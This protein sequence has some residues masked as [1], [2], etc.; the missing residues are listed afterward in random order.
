MRSTILR[1]LAAVGLPAL[2]LLAACGSDDDG[3]DGAGPSTT[4]AGTVAP[5]EG[6]VADGRITICSDTP[7]EPFEFKDDDGNDTG[8]DIDLVGAIA[9]QAGLTTSVTDL[10][11]DGIL[12]S[13]AAGDCDVVAAAVT[14]TD[15]RKQQVDFSDPYFDADQSLLVKKDSGIASIADLEGE[16]VG[17]QTG[18]TGESYA[19]DNATG[20]TVKSFEDADGLFSALE[21]GEIVAILQD[22]P[23]NGFRST[24]DDSVEVVETYTTG[25]QYGFPVAKGNTEVL[26][27]VNTGLATLRGDGTYDELF[28][29]YFGAPEG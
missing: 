15:E 1:R 19:N 22:L 10:P 25:E 3:D 7:Y 8:F 21:A 24:K 11:F 2:L 29:K 14:I 12:G 4:A 5:P 9:A 23:V 6:L 17:V 16:T 26:E 13:L 28:T 27:F 20:A 18:T